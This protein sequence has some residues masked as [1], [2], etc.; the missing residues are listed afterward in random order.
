MQRA[1]NA[2]TCMKWS[3]VPGFNWQE[4]NEGLGD[5]NYCR[6]PDVPEGFGYNKMF[7]LFCFVN[8]GGVPT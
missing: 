2:A 6:N 4:S 8:Q 3:E 5:H 7:D 1:L